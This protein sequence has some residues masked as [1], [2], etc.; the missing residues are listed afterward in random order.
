MHRIPLLWNIHKI[1]H[2]AQNL[3]F[4]TIYHRHLLETLLET[5][6]HLLVTLALGTDLVAPFGIIF[7]TIDVLGH[8]NVRLNLGRLS[9][10]I[11][12]PQA[13]RIHHSVDPKHYDANFGNTFMLWDH[14]FGT[15][16]YDAANPPT[17][18][19][20]NKAFRWAS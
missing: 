12:T 5:P 8:S 7:M 6:I 3:S 1:D 4:S 17:A 9:Y 14:L 18:Y 16:F 19:G 10:F 15:F 11:S 2:S 13:H 20:V